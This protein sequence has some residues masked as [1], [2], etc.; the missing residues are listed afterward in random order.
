M[1]WDE[2]NSNNKYQISKQ[3]I[4]KPIISDEGILNKELFKNIEM[5]NSENNQLNSALTEWQ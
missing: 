1:S 2:G 4:N 3:I 5:L